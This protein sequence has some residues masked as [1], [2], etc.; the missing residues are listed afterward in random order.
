MIDST[1]KLGDK[2]IRRSI[3]EDKSF[4]PPKKP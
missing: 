4:E 3:K 1:K 2:K